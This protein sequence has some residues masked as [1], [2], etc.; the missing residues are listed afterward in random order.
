MIAVPFWSLCTDDRSPTPTDAGFREHSG[1]VGADSDGQ[2]REQR[3]V[4]Q[5]RHGK[6]QVARRLGI[7]VGL[8]QRDE[9]QSDHVSAQ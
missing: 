2:A 1:R 6:C 4:H 9:A 7:R 8:L 5:Q 3:S